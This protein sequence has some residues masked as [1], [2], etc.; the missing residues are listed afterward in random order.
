MKLNEIF[1][2]ED[3]PKVHFFY[4]QALNLNMFKLIGIAED[5]EKAMEMWRDQSF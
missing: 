3:K 5:G 2:V 1:I 4:K